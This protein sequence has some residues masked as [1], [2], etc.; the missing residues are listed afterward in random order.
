MSNREST[1]D[2]SA[3][4]AAQEIAQLK[5]LVEMVALMEFI[6]DKMGDSDTDERDHLSRLRDIFSS[7]K[8]AQ[9]YLDDKISKETKEEIFNH[10]KDHER[11]Y[12]N[13]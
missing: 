11:D 2:D 7:N 5:E 8:V 9:L 10:L 1:D 13:D 3:T 6:R 12:L 4:K